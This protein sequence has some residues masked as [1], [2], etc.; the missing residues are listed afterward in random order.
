MTTV[1]VNG[2]FDVLHFGH[3]KLFEYAKSLGNYL[4]VG[5]DSDQRIKQRKGESRPIQNAE[6]RKFSLECISFINEV[7]VFNSDEELEGLVK[8]CNPDYMVVGIE[9]KDKKV[10][11]SEYAKELVFFD[12]RINSTTKI[13]NQLL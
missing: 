1:W 6:Q 7:I 12:M 3:F 2:C 13:L 5:I 11:G 8:K 9:Y 4:V 10:I